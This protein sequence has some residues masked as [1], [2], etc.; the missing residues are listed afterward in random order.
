[1][2]NKNYLLVSGTLFCLVSAAHLLRLLYAL[3]ITI[4]EYPLPM[5]MSWIGFLVPALLAT[6]A[7]R[8]TRSAVQT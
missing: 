8:L 6:W 5:Y 2:S 3:P 4:E 7:F 1:M